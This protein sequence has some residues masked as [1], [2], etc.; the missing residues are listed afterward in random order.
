MKKKFEESKID[1]L[2]EEIQNGNNKEMIEKIIGDDEQ[3][4]KEFD[5]YLDVWEKSADLKAFDEIDAGADWKKVRSRMRFYKTRERIPLRTYLIRIAAVVVLAVSL[6]YFLNKLM[7]HVSHEDAIYTEFAANDL[8]RSI[9]LADGSV[10]SL[11]RGAK[12]IYNDGFGDLNRDIILEGE[13]YFEVTRNEALPFKVHS[14]NSTV[15]VLGTEFDVKADSSSVLVSVVSGKVALYESADTEN[16]I[17]LLADNTGFYNMSKNQ[18]KSET[19]LDQNILA[20]HT[21]KFV[22]RDLPL[23]E[24]CRVLADFY[25]LELITAKDLE[26]NESINVTCSTES[27]D[28][29]LYSINNSIV[30]DVRLLKQNELLIVSKK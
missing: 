13:A 14:N 12:I 16:R 27:L 19:S 1:K 20:W 5:Q 18:I 4:R 29:V 23:E 8:P 15:E 2:I 30:A 22:F 9:E 17:E 25:Q 24:V 7:V 10:I 11:N 28:D 21:R 3:S 26:F 6:A